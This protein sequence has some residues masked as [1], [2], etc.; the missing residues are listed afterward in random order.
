MRKGTEKEEQEDEERN[1]KR[2]KEQ[3][4]RKMYKNCRG[5]GG[6][7]VGCFSL[8]GEYHQVLKYSSFRA[9]LYPNPRARTKYQR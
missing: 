6:G 5:G 2:G 3:K 1:R 7:L 8:I 9:A 4:M